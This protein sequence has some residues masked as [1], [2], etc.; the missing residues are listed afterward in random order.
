MEPLRESLVMLM[1]ESPIQTKE[2][3]YLPHPPTEFQQL[4]QAADLGE[5]QKNRGHSIAKTSNPYVPETVGSYADPISPLRERDNQALTNLFH[6][7]DIHAIEVDLTQ[8]LLHLLP[9]PCWE[10][11]PLEFLQ[12]FL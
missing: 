4:Q 3:P 10:E 5:Q 2:R 11:D 9:E 1:R 7:D 8:M 6:R 12:E